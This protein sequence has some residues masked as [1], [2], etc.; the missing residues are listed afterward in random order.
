MRML[1]RKKNQDFTEAFLYFPRYARVI[2]LYVKQY[3]AHTYDASTYTCQC[4]Q[5][6]FF[7]RHAQN[8]EIHRLRRKEKLYLTNLKQSEVT[9]K[10]LVGYEH[11]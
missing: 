8:S 6:N 4:R 5:M 3:A 7:F 9:S 10:F 11:K 1:D 2:V